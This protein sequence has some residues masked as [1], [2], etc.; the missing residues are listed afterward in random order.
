MTD[1]LL[2]ALW[3]DI[4]AEHFAGSLRPLAQIAWLPLSDEDEGIE[5]FGVY[6]AKSHAIAIDERFKPDEAKVGDGDARETA[7]LEVVFR[8][9][10]HEMI[11]QAAHQQQLPSP[12]QH[13]SSFITVAT[14][15]AAS[16]GTAAPTP[17]TAPR[18][19]DLVPLLAQFGL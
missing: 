14:P 4:N 16:L 8:L 18:W 17:S 9:M 7:K 10:V 15:V 5:A 1:D 3:T 6:I 19:P 11:H 12:G 13:G 2:T